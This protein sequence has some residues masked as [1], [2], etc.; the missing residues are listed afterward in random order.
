MKAGPADP[1]GD[2]VTVKSARAADRTD[3]GGILLVNVASPARTGSPPLGMQ[4]LAASAM[5]AGI[6][7]ELLDLSSPFGAEGRDAFLRTVGRLRPQVIGLALY[8][9]TALWAYE[10]VRELGP[11]R[12]RLRVAGG[13]H[14]TA[15]PEEAL[16]RGFD[17]V[18]RGEGEG[19]LVALFQ[20][21]QRGSDLGAVEGIA[22]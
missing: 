13:P 3:C 11:G 19:T 16:A 10:L 15:C 6:P 5:E 4:Y 17:V 21:V 7:V 1:E 18:V 14:A 12:Q 8:T 20:A 22:Y 9:E 2:G